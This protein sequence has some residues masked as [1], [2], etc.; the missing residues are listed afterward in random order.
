VTTREFPRFGPGFARGLTIDERDGILRCLSADRARELEDFSRQYRAVR[1][2]DGYRVRSAEYYLALPW[3]PHDDP[4]HAIWTVRQRSFERFRTMVR[5]R[6]HRQPASIL[7]LGAGSGWLSHR[8]SQ[9]GCPVVAVDI[10]DDDVDGLGAAQHY[11]NGFCRV[12]ADFDDLP[13][14]P[15]QFDVVVFNGSLHYAPN[16]RATLTRVRSLVAPGGIIAV[17]DS[18]MFECPD[19]GRSMRERSRER[20]RD[21]YGV[22]NP[23]LPG[24]GFLLFSSLADTARALGFEAHFFESRGGMQWTLGRIAGRVR[25]GIQPPSFGVWWAA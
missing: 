12:Q 4:Q 16:V 17:I 14:A 23:V 5:S 3:T 15:R 24:E 22:A 10:H 13:F 19:A 21:Q 20:F 6:F 9:D 2:Q 18:P 8:M 11:G 25:H 1:D 7:D